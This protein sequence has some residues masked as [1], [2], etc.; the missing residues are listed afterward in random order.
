MA[1]WYDQIIFERKMYNVEIRFSK[2]AITISCI[3]HLLSSHSIDYPGDGLRPKL[4]DVNVFVDAFPT[5]DSTFNIYSDSS[6]R[7][8]AVIGTMF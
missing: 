8:W 7:S 3:H 2:E 4:S 1:S 5:L 6:P